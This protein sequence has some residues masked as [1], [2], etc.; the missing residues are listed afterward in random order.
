MELTN[1]TDLPDLWILVQALC[2]YCWTDP[3]SRNIQW[4]SRKYTCELTVFA[5]GKNCKNGNNS[6]YIA[7]KNNTFIVASRKLKRNVL[8]A[9]MKI[10]TQKFFLFAVWITHWDGSEF[11]HLQRTRGWELFHCEQLSQIFNSILCCFPIKRV[12]SNFETLQGSC[13]GYLRRKVV[14]K[15]VSTQVPDAQAKIT[16][17]LS[18]S[19]PNI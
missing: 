17:A 16:Y 5:T 4:G 11:K 12:L 1:F 14:L 2:S 19:S 8:K 3:C 7:Q 10:R 15:F 9:A 6:S 13:V 18:V